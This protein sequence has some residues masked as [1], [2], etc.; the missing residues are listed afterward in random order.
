MREDR[1]A[2]PVTRNQQ[3]AARQPCAVVRTR[4]VH[5]QPLAR[6]QRS[7]S[8]PQ[9]HG[10]SHGT[11]GAPNERPLNADVA[12]CMLPS[13]R[14]SPLQGRLWFVAH[15]QAEVLAEVVGRVPATGA[16]TRIKA[17]PKEPSPRSRT[18]GCGKPPKPS[19]VATTRTQAV[20]CCNSAPAHCSVR[21]VA[22]TRDRIDGTR[23]REYPEY[24][25]TRALSCG[26]QQRK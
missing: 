21:L 17:R 12:C 8:I 24:P 23:G 25:C 18:I 15:L 2:H 14:L 20:V 22:C 1:A 10:I 11:V 5:A 9:R 26:H 4:G 6:D 16:P 3:R 19:Y 7:Q 13:A